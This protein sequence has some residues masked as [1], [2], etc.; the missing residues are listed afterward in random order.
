MI[1]IEKQWDID[2]IKSLIVNDIKQLDE[3]MEKRNMLLSKI[4]FDEE[5][6]GF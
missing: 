2:Y 6:K 5:L 3:K 4:R 1:K